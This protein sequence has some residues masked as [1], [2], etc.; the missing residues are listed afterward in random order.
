AGRTR[1]GLL[2]VVAEGP[3]G[4]VYLAPGAPPRES[5]D[6]EPEEQIFDWPGR[7]NV[8]RYGMTQFGDL[9]TDRQ[10]VAL[11]TFS[12]LVAE[13]RDVVERDALNAGLAEDGRRLRD[14]GSGPA[15]YAD[16]IATYMAFAVDRTADRHST[17]CGWDSGKEH[18]RNV[19]AR[20]AIPMTWDFA[21]NNPFS[22]SS[23]NWLNMIDWVWKVVGQL[24]AGRPGDIA[25][26]DAGARIAENAPT[27]LSTDP[28]YYHNISYAGLS[29]YCY[30]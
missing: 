3:R 16:A 26:R 22:D 7:T 30:V 11:N 4:R 25:R 10:L 14:G 8:V 20:Q 6:W 5:P 1:E 13:V 12:D 21:E 28:P 17:I 24:P 18:A 29:D 2:A 9:F 15:A 19:F 23:G 27:V